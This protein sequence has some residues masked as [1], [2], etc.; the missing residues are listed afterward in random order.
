MAS[1]WGTFSGCWPSSAVAMAQA[2]IHCAAALA[3]GCVV[4]NPAY[5]GRA[6]SDDMP[7]DR[8]D[9]S[10]EAA[11]SEVG[12]SALNAP[13]SCATAA[14]CPAGFG[15]P[16]GTC[17]LTGGLVLHW[18]L[19]EAS[20]SAALDASGNGVMGSYTGVSGAPTPSTMV[21][22]V[23]FPDPHS[24][25]F[26]MANDHGVRLASMPAALKPSN[27]LTLAAWYRTSLVDSD[28]SGSTGSEIVSAGNQYLIRVR[29][30]QAEFAKRSGASGY[31]QCFATVS[32]HRD[33]QW[34]HLAGISSSS[35]MKLYLDGLERCTSSN[36]A[37]IV[38]DQSTELW[39]GRHGNGG[40]DWS[41]EG[42]IDDVRIYNRALSAAEITWLARGGE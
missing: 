2:V 10:P 31:A 40:R 25:A 32:N 42:N 7:T 4:P 23:T 38:Y 37:D 12:D 15:C 1:S 28:A 34:H 39:V 18:R 29:A 13:V 20:G 26:V 6:A 41:F 30:T 33:G 8:P 5:E 16:A 9:G 35:G 19:D 27:N 14:D 11:R 17:A 21:P 22:T 24:R 36:V 3:A